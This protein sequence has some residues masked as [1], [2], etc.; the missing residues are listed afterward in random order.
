MAMKALSIVLIFYVCGGIMGGLI[1]V[2][3][4]SCN[5]VSIHDYCLS[6]LPAQ[7]HVTGLLDVNIDIGSL[8]F[9]CFHPVNN[10]V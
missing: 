3:R 5:R 9:S 8:G 4:V 6:V 2:H 7:M 1:W 10:E